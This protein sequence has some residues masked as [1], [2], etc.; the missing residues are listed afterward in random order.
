[1]RISDWSSDVCSSDLVLRGVVGVRELLVLL[2]HVLAEDALECA[3][4]GDRAGVVEPA[5]L[6]RVGELQDVLRAVEV[7]APEG[8][9]IGL[10]D[11]GRTSWRESR[12][13][14]VTI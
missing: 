5:D 1:M 11:V 14:K 13:Q 4:H 3:G 2:E 8:I 12:W 10:H 7:R 9:L 6:D